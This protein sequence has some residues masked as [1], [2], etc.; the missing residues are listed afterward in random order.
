MWKQKSHRRQYQH[1]TK[2]YA[3]A[4]TQLKIFVIQFI[5]SRLNSGEKETVSTLS[6]GGK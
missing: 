2:D 6:D 3:D 4:E 5:T 1:S